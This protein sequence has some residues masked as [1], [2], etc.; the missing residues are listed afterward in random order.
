MVFSSMTFLWIFLPLLCGIYFISKEKYRNTILL[1]F[2]LVFYSWGEP[3]YIIVMLSS[4]IINYIL[5]LILDK[6]RNKKEKEYNINIINN[7][8][9]RII[10]IF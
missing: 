8:Q 7:I 4:I 3:K 1:I 6:V 9:F 5:G 2:S 10:R